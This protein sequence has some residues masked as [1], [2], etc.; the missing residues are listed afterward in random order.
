MGQ[1]PSQP[2]V[3]IRLLPDGS[4]DPTFNFAGWWTT[5]SSRVLM[6][7]SEGRYLIHSGPELRRVLADGS[8]DPTFSATSSYE[9]FNR[10]GTTFNVTWTADDGA[11]YAGG[12][13]DTINGSG[14]VKITKFAQPTL[15]NEFV[16]QYSVAQAYENGGNLY[17]GVRRL[18]GTTAGSVSYTTQNGTAIAGTDFAATSGALQWED[19]ETGIQYIVIPIIDNDTTDPIRQFTVLLNNPTGGA[20]RGDA[21]ITVTI[22]D[23][24]GLPQISAQPTDRTIFAQTATTLTVGISSITAVS[25]QWQVEVDGEF[26]DIPGAIGQS[27][28]LQ[29]ATPGITDG[30]YRVVVTNNNGSVESATAQVTVV[31]PAGASDPDF[32][33]QGTGFSPFS[34]LR[35][36]LQSD[37]SILA[38]GSFT[39]F[40]GVAL[41]VPYI[42]RL[43]ADGELDPSWQPGLNAANNSIRH[44]AIHPE[45]S[46]HAGK[47]VVAGTFTSYA[48]TTVP[49]LARLNSDGTF[50]ASWIPSAT[51]NLNDFAVG[52]ETLA[53][54]AVIVAYRT[55]GLRKYNA[56]GS[57]AFNFASQTGTTITFAVQPDGKIVEVYTTSGPT[58]HWVR[59]HLADGSL[60]PDFQ[61]PGSFN[62]APAAIAFSPD[63]KIYL[64]GV[65]LNLDG[66]PATRLVRLLPNGQR[67]PE[68][69]IEI[70]GTLSNILA[71]PDGSLMAAGAFNNTVNGTAT[72]TLFRILA[73]GTLDPS[74]FSADGAKTSLMVDAQGRYYGVNDG[75]IRRFLGDYG[76][77][78]FTATE[79]VTNESAGT[80]EI[81]VQRLLGTRGQVSVS[82][83]IVGGTAVAGVDF[84]NAAS[85]TL[86]WMPGDGEPQSIELNL[87]DDTLAEEDKTVVIRL[88]DPSD[89]TRL[90]MFSDIEIIILDTDSTPRILSQPVSRTRAENLSATFSVTSRSPFEVNYQWYLNGVLIPGATDAT[91][92]IESVAFA[93]A[94]NYVVEVS[95]INGTTTSQTAVLTVLPA[96]TA[97]AAGWSNQSAFNNA[98]SAIAPLG[99][100]RALVGGSFSL[101]RSRIAMV[102]ASG[103]I[104]PAFTPQTSNV[105]GHFVSAIALQDDGKILIGGRFNTFGGV[106]AVNL[107][108][109]NSDFTVDTDFQLLLNGA[110]DN[111]VMAI[112]V[113]PDGRILIGGTF[114]RIGDQLGTNA[115]ARLNPDGSVD[116]S[117]TSR[118]TNSGSVQVIRLADN[119]QIYLGGT[120]TGYDNGNRVVR[121]NSDGSRDLSFNTTHAS[122]TVRD[123]L[124]LDNG[125]VLIAGDFNTAGRPY[126]ARLNASGF[127]L[128]SFLSGVTVN[129]SVLSMAQQQNG[130]LVF[131]GNFTTFGTPS[132]YFTRTESDGSPDGTL[133]L[134]S[135]FSAVVNRVALD[136]DGSIWVAGNF[137]NYQGNPATRLIRLAGDAVPLEIGRQPAAPVAVSGQ[138]VS[139]SVAAAGFGPLTYQWFKGDPAQAVV[140]GDGITGAN[141]AT[142]TF[143]PYSESDA[144]DYFVR[145]TNANGDTLDSEIVSVAT[146]SA[147]I[148]IEQPQSAIISSNHKL[149]LRVQASG[150]PTLSYSWTRDGTPVGTNKPYLFL[151]TLTESDSGN[152]QVTVSNTFG[153][154]NSAVA[155]I[156]IIPSPAIHD[157]AFPLVAGANAFVLPLSSGQYAL[158]GTFTTVRNAANQ[159]I[160]RSRFAIFEADGSVHPA[161]P[162][163]NSA[164]GTI[165]ELPDGSLLLGGNFA[166]VG[167]V[168]AAHLIKLNPDF[169]LN[170]EFSDFLGSIT[171][172]VPSQTRVSQI[173]PLSDGRIFI[174]GYFDA[175][176]GLP[177]T[178]SMAILHPEGTVDTNFISPANSIVALNAVVVDNQD[179]LIVSSNNQIGTTTQSVYRI[180][181]DGTIDPTFNPALDG[182]AQTLAMLDDG[183]ILAGSFY[184]Q[185]IAPDGTLV[186]AFA[187]NFAGMNSGGLIQYLQVQDDGKILIGGTFQLIGDHPRNRMA[188]LL[189]DGTLDLIFDTRTGFN[190]NI[191]TMRLAPNGK[192][193]VAGSFLNF[194]GVAVNN[195]AVLT[196]SPVALGFQKKP[197]D[198]DLVAGAT[199]TLAST[200]IGTSSVTY[201]W[202]L[203]GVDLVDG[204]GINGAN[205]P[206]LTVEDFGQGDVG[207][208]SITITN[209]AGSRTASAQVNL[210]AAPVVTSQPKGGIYYEDN[211]LVLRAAG[212]AA[213]SATWQWYKDNELLEGATSQIVR[214]ESAT[215]ANSGTYVAVLTNDLGSVETDP[216]TIT[217]IR[218]PAG[219]I[220]GFPANAGIGNNSINAIV[221]MSDGSIIIGGNFTSAGSSPGVGMQSRPR[222]A[223]FNSDGTLDANFNPAPNNAIQALAEHQGALLV[224][225]FFSTMAGTSGLTNFAKLNTDGTLDST[226]IANLGTGPNSSVSGILVDNANRIYVSGNF[227]TWD[228]TPANRLVRLLAD[229]TLDSSFAFPTSGFPSI[230]SMAIQGDKLLV[231][232][233]LFM[234]TGTYLIRVNSDGSLDSDFL[235]L[236]TGNVLG[237]AVQSDGRI[238]ASGSFNNIGGDTQYAGIV[239]LLTDGALDTSFN[240]GPVSLSGTIQRVRVDKSGRILAAGSFISI[241][242]QGSANIARLLPNGQ[243]DPLF[244]AGTS[245]VAQPLK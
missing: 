213:P 45:S 5:F 109:L 236:P 53:D 146:A 245:S 235:S 120:F 177:G 155:T 2:S 168:P 54:G 206:V 115:I 123:I 183:S 13:F 174:A 166:F 62:S 28:T 74:F 199:L 144:G 52:V 15:A 39:S 161:N 112:Q 27:F 3:L 76:A 26:V 1:V 41:Q 105:N 106:A 180:L 75:L 201:Q 242:G 130:R 160:S 22:L 188:R 33:F 176:A 67:D 38:V 212:K 19:G 86:H 30:T 50:D 55:A 118:I 231:G 93:N 138:S 14:S 240:P 181:G 200:A 23:D 8:F 100:G 107:V 217:V 35:T 34:D 66:V 158:G 227:S 209:E 186:T 241:G 110:P 190:G 47:I 132:N 167:G 147:P 214:I 210:L 169:T 77:F 94:G 192:I 78:S 226:F 208:Y 233:N 37:G 228:G 124:L 24:E 92:H 10:P 131:G 87:L 211:P 232:G 179:R 238:V 162:A 63:G 165:A 140:N 119:G 202:Q 244:D 12:Y 128:P 95:N 108:R 173:I 101:P 4:E 229:G 121:I 82:W 225:G 149:L 175:V 207:T 72:T 178:R 7:D 104:D 153:S 64:A 43:T 185:K 197:F 129:N 239:R 69:S 40:N 150:A 49:R 164:V 237:L 114:S 113:Q 48:G 16:W 58:R 31:L 18:G 243:R 127:L 187:Q 36:R 68:F 122:S 91:Y 142:L 191:A 73:D 198:Q 141:S 25:F 42:L 32:L 81:P 46:P 57:F 204:L 222:L 88:T 56:D 83:E 152:Y 102:N 20:I 61:Q 137:Q 189:P 44:V 90:G 133:S 136:A 205:S 11:V 220:A 193:L 6:A 71:L 97:V 21:S 218:N 234:A 159:N 60:D 154:V 148:L 194:N 151:P 126:I 96:P 143:S 221:P 195:F 85:G 84:V 117:F 184:L 182:N 171:S 116:T 17:L 139:I 80:V 196:G 65:F 98:V 219:T 170:T 223:R 215:A 134:Q 230:N 224:G 51:V 157:P 203:D 89:L 163:P 99:D 125:D 59:R 103:A 111:D 145:I 135:G 216:V 9:N 156:E 172:S 70:V 29:N 79:L